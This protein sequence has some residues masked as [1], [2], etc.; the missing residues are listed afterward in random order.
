MVRAF[1]RSGYGQS[2]LRA[3]CSLT[4][5]AGE[6]PSGQGIDRKLGSFTTFRGF[7]RRFGEPDTGSRRRAAG[8]DLSRLTPVL[9]TGSRSLVRADSFGV[10][11][12]GRRRLLRIAC[13]ALV[14]LLALAALWSPQPASIPVDELTSRF[15]ARAS[16]DPAHGPAKVVIPDMAMVGS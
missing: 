3:E 4:R 5:P 6:Q 1:T 2:H 10:V 9:R 16:L 14:L 13:L 12:P 8:S 15:G 11:P 7:G